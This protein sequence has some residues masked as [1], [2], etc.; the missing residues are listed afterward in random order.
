MFPWRTES[1]SHVVL[2]YSLTVEQNPFF[3]NLFCFSLWCLLKPATFITSIFFFLFP[4][5]IPMTLNVVGFQFI[6]LTYYTLIFL[7]P[8]LV[9]FLEKY[10][11][12]FIFPASS[13]SFLFFVIF[14]LISV[15]CC[16]LSFFFFPLFFYSVVHPVQGPAGSTWGRWLH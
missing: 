16:V 7:K 11:L 8:L 2:L 10:F 14:L 6:F 4:F 3:P 9:K 1:L 5:A 15:Q 12:V 13:I